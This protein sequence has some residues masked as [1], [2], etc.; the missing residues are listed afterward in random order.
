M[1]DATPHL[2]YPFRVR[3]GRFV[4][5]DQNSADHVAQRAEVALRTR[6]GMLEAQPEFGLRSLIGSTG[7]VGPVV[8]AALERAGLTGRFLTTEDD[9]Q[10]AGHIRNVLVQIQDEPEEE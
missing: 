10:V 6:P 7:P 2:A 3:G 5:V 1:P 9:S 4:T 8:T